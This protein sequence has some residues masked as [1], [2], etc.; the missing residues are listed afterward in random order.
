MREAGVNIVVIGNPVYLRVAY[1]VTMMSEANV[2]VT[3]VYSLKHRALYST[4]AL[5]LLL[6]TL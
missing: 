3:D 5:S 2:Y 6:A 4:R 1:E